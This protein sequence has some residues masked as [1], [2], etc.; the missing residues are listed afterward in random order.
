MVYS[1]KIDAKAV[2]VIVDCTG[3]ESAY[4]NRESACRDR[5]IAFR[6]LESASQVLKILEGACRGRKS[7]C[8][9]VFCV[10]SVGALRLF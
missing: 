4:K 3:R 1:K 10:N 6:G 7:S 8:V 5:E 2:K 9:F